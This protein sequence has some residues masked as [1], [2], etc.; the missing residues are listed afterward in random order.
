MA[1]PRCQSKCVARSA[2]DDETFICMACG[3]AGL[4]IRTPLRLGKPAQYG[5]PRGNAGQR[6]GAAKRWGKAALTDAQRDEIRR[7]YAAGGISQA[8]LAERYRVSPGFVCEI[9][10]DG[11][12]P[13]RAQHRLT[14]RD[15]FEIQR[16]YDGGGYTYAQLGVKFGVTAGRIGQVLAGTPLQRAAA[17]AQTARA[18]QAEYAAGGVTQREL[19]L[20][21]RRSAYSVNKAIKMDL[22]ENNPIKPLAIA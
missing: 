2:Y 20:K 11:K 7:E 17:E 8:A 5:R 18:I 15:K 19:G 10:N 3:H 21:Y 14:Q 9:V 16:L 1:C 22:G 12:P 13:K 4:A 6:K